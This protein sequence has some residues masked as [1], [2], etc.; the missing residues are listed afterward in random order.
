MLKNA[1]FRSMTEKWVVA[2][3][4]EERRVYGVGTTAE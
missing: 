4:I 2:V 1:S 3:G